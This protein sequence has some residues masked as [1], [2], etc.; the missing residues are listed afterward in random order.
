MLGKES[1]EDRWEHR[2]KAMRC[3][4]CMFFVGKKMISPSPSFQK[5]MM[6][7]HKPDETKDNFDYSPGRILT[8]GEPATPPK[9]IGRTIGRCR[10][11]APTMN[12]YPVV[13]SDD[14]CGDHKIDENKVT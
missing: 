2:N 13:F 10:R 3:K 1:M 7:E 4:T 11:R 9:F 6:P 14:W 12:G 5:I 8:Q